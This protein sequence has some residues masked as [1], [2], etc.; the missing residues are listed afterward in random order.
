MTGQVP[1][2][3][4]FLA[5]AHAILPQTLDVVVYGLQRMTRRP[6]LDVESGAYSSCH[7]YIN[8]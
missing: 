3:V 6:Q 2:T 5:A 8:L 4:G 1:M 7:A